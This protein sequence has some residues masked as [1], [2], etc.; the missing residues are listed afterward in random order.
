MYVYFAC[1]N[2]QVDT[3][4]PWRSLL[5]CPMISYMSIQGFPMEKKAQSQDRIQDLNVGHL[6]RVLNEFE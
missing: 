4:R 1:K 6:I 2:V 5:S 3:C